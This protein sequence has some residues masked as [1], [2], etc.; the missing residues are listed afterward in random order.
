LT[1]Q[2]C[3]LIFVRNATPDELSIHPAGRV[4]EHCHS[5]GDTVANE[6][7]RLAHPRAVGICRH[8]NNV[9]RLD[10]LVDKEYP[11]GGSKKRFSGRGHTNDDSPYE[12]D[13]RQD[14][15]PA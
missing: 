4:S 10:W 3:R 13:H 14:P 2:S 8:D 11:S 6:V 12:K 9:R 7:G 15:G 1:R 5:S